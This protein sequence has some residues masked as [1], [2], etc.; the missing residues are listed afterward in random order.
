MKKLTAN[1]ATSEKLGRSTKKIVT[2]SMSHFHMSVNSL[3]RFQLHVA[4]ET[5]PTR[6]SGNVRMRTDGRRQRGQPDT[7][8]HFSL[9]PVDHWTGILRKPSRRTITSST[10]H[11]RTRYVRRRRGHKRHN[12]MMNAQAP[13][14]KHKFL[15]QFSLNSHTDCSVVLT[16]NKVSYDFLQ[17]V[18]LKYE[19]LSAS[20]SLIQRK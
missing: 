15:I 5:R 4:E 1:S 2:L 12:Q 16:N 8:Y 11:I 20:C 3:C 19:H 6:K 13:E 9:V 10:R 17:K 7:T 18:K 14:N